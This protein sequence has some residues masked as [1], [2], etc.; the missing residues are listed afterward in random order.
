MHG[1]LKLSKTAEMII[2]APL[3]AI[4]MYRERACLIDRQSR[5]WI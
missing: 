1:S 2:A 3:I 4:I 5:L